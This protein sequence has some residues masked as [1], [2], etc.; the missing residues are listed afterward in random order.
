MFQLAWWILVGLAIGALA[1]LI[2][3]G[4]DPLGWAATLV[5]GIAGS[6]LG[7]FIGRLFFGSPGEGGFATGGFVISL[8]GAILLL[9]VWRTIRA[10]M[11]LD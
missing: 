8:V 4:N 2:F 1:R 11:T 5:L 9:L 6:V 10:R 7:G 3:P